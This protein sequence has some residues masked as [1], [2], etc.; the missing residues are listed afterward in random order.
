MNL[1]PLLR[2]CTDNT[3]LGGVPGGNAIKGIDGGRVPIKMCS[4]QVARAGFVPQMT[5]SA[6]PAMKVAMS[7]RLFKQQPDCYSFAAL[8]RDGGTMWDSF[9]NALV[10]RHLRVCQSGIASKKQIVAIFAK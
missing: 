4:S 1:L 9:A 5:K 2:A 3:I 10:F 7:R 8:G 6:L